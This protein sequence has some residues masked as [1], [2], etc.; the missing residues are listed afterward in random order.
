MNWTSLTQAISN[1]PPHELHHKFLQQTET[2]ICVLVAPNAVDALADLVSR[3]GGRV[4]F[5]SDRTSAEDKKGLPHLHN[6]LWKHTT[7]RARRAEP[8]MTCLRMGYPEDD[9]AACIAIAERCEGEVINH[10]AFTRS[11]ADAGMIATTQEFNPKGFLNPGRMIGQNSPDCA[12]VPHREHG[13]S[14]LQRTAA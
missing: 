3:D 1:A 6:L 9:I 8:E 12:H 11:D 4:A 13:F 2:V 10:V 14:D 7:L 5:R